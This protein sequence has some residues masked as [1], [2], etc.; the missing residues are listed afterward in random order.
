MAQLNEFISDILNR[1][2]TATSIK[3]ARIF[4]NQFK[5]VEAG[6]Y[7]S[8]PFPCAFVE[9]QY[10]SAGYGVTSDIK[11]RIHIG[12]QELDAMDGTLDQNFNV[13]TLRDEVVSKLSGF[14]AR[15]GSVFM[16]T[17]DEWDYRHGNVYEWVVEFTCSFFDSSKF[18]DTTIIKAPNTD[19]EIDVDVVDA[20]VLTPTQVGEILINGK[21]S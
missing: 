17:G 5:E 8:F 4:N 14:E 3:Y 1:I 19:L 13:Y 6:N 11:V 2:T 20:S 10:A 7:Y 15:G 12:H 9:L 16:Q 21:T 18:P